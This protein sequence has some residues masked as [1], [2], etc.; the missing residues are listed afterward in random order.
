MKI[1]ISIMIRL[2]GTSFIISY[3]YENCWNIQKKI[4]KIVRLRPMRVK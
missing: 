3:Y 1:M 4:Y 2:K